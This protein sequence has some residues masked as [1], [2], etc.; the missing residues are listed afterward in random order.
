VD[1][2]GFWDLI[3]TSRA[4]IGT[5]GP[6]AAVEEQLDAL[7]D[8]VSELPTEQLIAFQERLGDQTSRAHSWRVW[9]AGYLAAG[10]MSDDAFEYF[11]LW[12][13]LQGRETFERV[14]TDP[15]ALA[16]LS[17]D[18]HGAA[19]DAAE[20]FAYLA[21]DVLS[22]RGIAP[23]EARAPVTD[24]GAP[25][26]VPFDEDD[27]D[28]FAATFPRLSARTARYDGAPGGGPDRDRITDHDV[29]RFLE[30]QREE[31]DPRP[32]APMSPALAAVLW[33]RGQIREQDRPMVAAHWLA[34]ELGGEAVLELAS[35]R[36]DEREVGELWPLALQE[37]GVA[38]PVTDARAAMKWAAQRVLDG[39][40]DARWLVRMLEMD[41]HEVDQQDD[42]EQLV[43]MIDDWLDWTERDLRSQ[44]TTVHDR[45]RSARNRLSEAVEA[46]ARDDV[47][48]ALRML[49]EWRA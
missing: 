47:A 7:R 35:L 18:V 37:L 13:V 17:W 49:E 10:G 4:D 19:F 5:A 43:L 21:P 38:V 33:E 27:D 30:R 39:E 2:D 23:H 42:F 14:I 26:G 3:T 22:A 11:R 8:R 1:A 25:R 20:D 16:E 29:A 36:G 15:D 46:M 31:K 12:L 48:V 6:D 28:W 45:A 34:E 41:W 9:A 24:T 44:E 40:R 32:V